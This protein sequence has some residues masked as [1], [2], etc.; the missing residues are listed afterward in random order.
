MTKN[1]LILVHGMIP[2]PKPGDHKVIYKAL[3]TRLDHE[4]PQLRE[5]IDA[6]IDIEWGHQPEAVPPGGFRPDQRITAA[7]NYIHQQVSFDNV[8]ADH[9]ADNHLLTGL[10]D[11]AELPGVATRKITTP[12]KETILLLGVTDVFYYCSPD[13]EQAIRNA[14]YGQLLTGLQPFRND[15]QVRL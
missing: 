7:E 3:R 8:S 13:G 6:Q 10:A 15:D 9:S 12:I 4:Q 14:V 11:L 5:K 2:D 1:I